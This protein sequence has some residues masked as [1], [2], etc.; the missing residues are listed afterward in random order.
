[1]IGLPAI[2][3]D[4]VDVRSNS[5]GLGP[6]RS[7]DGNRIDPERSSVHVRSFQ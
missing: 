5:V 1:M 3:V 4:P 6:G 7:R 2:F